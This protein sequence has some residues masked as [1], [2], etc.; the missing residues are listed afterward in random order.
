MAFGGTI[1]Y[2]VEAVFNDPTLAEGYKVA[3]LDAANKIA[4]LA[5]MS[6]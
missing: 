2:L 3:A 1:D 5:R 6:G 4:A